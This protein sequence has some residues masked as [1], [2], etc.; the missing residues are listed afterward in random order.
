MKELIVSVVLF[1]SVAFGA[2]EEPVGLRPPKNG[3]VY[4]VAHRGAHQGVPENTLAAYR[5]AIELGADFVEVDIQMTKDGRFVSV[6]NSDIAKYVPGRTDKVKDLT[7]GELQAFD[8][9]SVVGPKWQGERI[10]SFAE[11]LDVCKGKIGIYIDLKDAPVKPLVKLIQERGME[12]DVV[13]YASPAEL[14]E[15]REL[16]PR[17][18]LM[19]DPGPEEKLPPLLERFKPKVVATVWR[20]HRKTLVDMCHA[21]GA[22]VIAD[23][24]WDH[25]AADLKAGK[26]PRCWLDALAWGT[27]GIQTDRPEELI[28]FLK[29]RQAKTGAA[30]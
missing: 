7:L 4:V 17:S 18:L 22:A 20:H 14:A 15:L 24:D 28:A 5:K 16:A 8:V 25:V 27:D 19:P 12:R 13:W 9:G 23:E 2:S 30:E 29:E 1:T 11:I 3:G 21:A 10:P 6:H 26:A